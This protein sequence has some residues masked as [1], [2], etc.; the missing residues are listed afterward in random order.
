MGRLVTRVGPLIAAC[1]DQ[2]AEFGFLGC[3]ELRLLDGWFREGWSN[4]SRNTYFRLGIN[5]LGIN[6]S[7]KSNRSYWSYTT[8]FPSELLKSKP[9]SPNMDWVTGG[10]D[11]GALTVTRG[12]ES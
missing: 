2:L 8:L 1:R 7:D 9:P 6:R 3:E 12:G 11:C 5:R 4:R 10:D